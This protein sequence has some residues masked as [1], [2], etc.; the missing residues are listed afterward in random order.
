M[1]RIADIQ[2]ATARHFDLP[3]DVMM[4]PDGRGARVR[5]RARARQT[6]MYLSACLTAQGYASIGRRFHRDHSTVICAIR[7]TR[8]RL[9]EDEGT[10]QHVREIVRAVL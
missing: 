3:L 8:K 2:L 6:A 4:E 1:I 10:R 5:S 9:R 7:A